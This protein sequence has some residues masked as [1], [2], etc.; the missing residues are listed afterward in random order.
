MTI[1]AAGTWIHGGYEHEG[2]GV[3]Y[4]VFGAGYG[5]DA[6]FDGLAEHLQHLPWKFRKLIEEKHSVVG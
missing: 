3:V 2:S 5:D 1:V 6:V 4:G